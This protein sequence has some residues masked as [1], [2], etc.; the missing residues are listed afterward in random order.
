VHDRRVGFTSA[1]RRARSRS[2]SNN[3]KIFVGYSDITALQAAMWSRTGL[4][5]VQGPAVLPQWGEYGGLDEFTWTSWEQTLMRPVAAGDLPVSPAWWSERL[6]Y[7]V[8]DDRP[9]R[10]EPNTGPRVVREGVGEGPIVAANLCTLLLLVGTPWWPD[11]D[12]ALLCLETAEEEQAW[13]AERSLHHLRHLGVWDQVAGLAFGRCHPDSQIEPAELD[14]MLLS[15]TRG[16]VFPI[17]VDFD[18]GH[19]DP[20][21]CLPWGIQARLEG[22]RLTL[23]EPAV[24]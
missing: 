7:D 11:L 19:T 12:G 16:T 18:F 22:A 17:A 1:P 5:V 21:C 20:M 24:S 15:S 2:G 10:R 8:E 14:R 3:P 9:K 6:E 13:W 23:L 4:A